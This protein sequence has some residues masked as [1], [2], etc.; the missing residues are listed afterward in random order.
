MKELN[1]SCQN[2]IQS[3]FDAHQQAGIKMTHYLDGTTFC[4]DGRHLNTL[5][6]PKVFTP[7]D[8]AIFKNLVTITTT[9]FDKIIFHYQTHADYRK[10]F[11]F[12]PELEELIC[13][14][15]LFSCALPMARYDIFY[16][17][18]SHDFKFCE[19]NTDGTSAMNEVRELENALSY[20]LATRKLKKYHTFKTFK[21]FDTWIDRMMRLYREIPGQPES[22]TV[23]IVDFI[24][25]TPSKQD[26]LEE[27][28]EFKRHFEKK[29]IPTVIADI[30][31]LKYINGSLQTED[32][33]PIQII[34][35][36]AV[37]SDIMTHYAEVPD[38]IQ[39]VKDQAVILFGPM[40]TQIIHNKWLFAVIHDD[41]TKAFLTP[42]EN[43][44]VATHF[45][46]TYK[47][48]R[49]KINTLSAVETKDDWIVKPVDSYA[50]H[51]V[52]AGVD[53]SVNEWAAVLEDCADD[54]YI[55]QAYTQPYRSTNID[56]SSRDPQLK[57]YINMTGLYV[58]GGRLAGF[59]S[60]QSDGGIVCSGVN[61]K[62]V[63]TLELLEE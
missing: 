48:T 9:I 27:F 24:D 37:T 26:S 3:H 52:H 17:E 6:F 22:P 25:D 49:E 14:P 11:P 58:F 10:L 41:A 23:A 28:K 50:C 5:Y 7:E 19:I 46:A 1:E 32:G 62:A 34:Y 55:I 53:L 13:L 51:G 29:G 20:N 40:S 21:L 15:T 56:F 59:Y 35:R 12:S 8:L 36:R 4:H 57:A 63:P 61:E 31:S 60:R 38:F 44:F 54:H 30:R 43:D 45:P 47:L 39:A 18:V 16:D 42:H 2:M 33:T